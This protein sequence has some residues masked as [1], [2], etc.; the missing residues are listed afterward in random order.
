MR[1]IAANPVSSRYSTLNAVPSTQAILS[2]TKLPFGLHIFPF[3]SN[4]VC[5]SPNSKKTF[6]SS[7]QLS[8]HLQM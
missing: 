5:D 2:Q 6:G 7:T 4:D 8:Y 3:S 1:A